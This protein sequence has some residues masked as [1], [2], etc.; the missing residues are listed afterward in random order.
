MI[1]I[2]IIQI[3]VIAFVVMNRLDEIE[4]LIKNKE[5]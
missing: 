3:S 5:E 1:S 2:V 4:E